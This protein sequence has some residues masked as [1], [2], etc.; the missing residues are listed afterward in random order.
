MM[1]SQ[2][3]PTSRETSGETL[4][5]IETTL[6]V[7]FF[8][9]L[10]TVEIPYADER[11]AIAAVLAQEEIPLT[12]CIARVL[13]ENHWNLSDM[14]GANRKKSW[15]GAI[16][17]LDDAREAGAG[18][19]ALISGPGPSDPSQRP[20]ALKCLAGSMEQ[21]CRAAQVEPAVKV[22]LEPL[23]F[24]AHK[25]ASLG[26]TSEGADLCRA[27]MDLG[28]ELYF[29]LDTA[30]MILNEE[31]PVEALEAIQSMVPEYH[32]CNC[33]TDLSH[34]LYGD[35][36][37]PFGSPGVMDADVIAEIMRGQLRIGYFSPEKRPGVFCE[38]LKRPEDESEWTFQHVLANLKKAWEKV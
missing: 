12:Y 14:D 4:R 35:R 31:D 13:N 20:E 30:H 23:D 38:V 24:A 18:A 15:E 25:K 6:K 34:P 1:I 37:L 26:R 33:V 9:A 22:V 3:W 36:H 5:A 21:I 27:M 2:T 8:E 7:G 28:L 19:L 10:Q 16:R 11:R 32:Y 17:T 29:C